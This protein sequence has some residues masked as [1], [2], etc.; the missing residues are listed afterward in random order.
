M[1]YLSK[2]VNFT[3]EEMGNYINEDYKSDVGMG[4]TTTTNERSFEFAEAQFQ[5]IETKTQY[6][7]YT[8]DLTETLI[9]TISDF[10]SELVSQIDKIATDLNVSLEINYADTPGASGLIYTSDSGQDVLIGMHLRA[11]STYI[12]NTTYE[13]ESIEIISTGETIVNEN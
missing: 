9:V 2:E 6:R 8:S 5:I 3:I 4:P 7:D 11:T 1:Q 13:I 12:V 10:D